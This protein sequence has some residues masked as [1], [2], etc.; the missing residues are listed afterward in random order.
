MSI[1]KKVLERSWPTKYVVAAIF[2]LGASLRIWKFIEGGPVSFDEAWS[3]WLG[4][5]ALS[6]LFRIMATDKHPPLFYLLMHFWN[7][8]YHSE[9]WIRIP[10]L[11]FSLSSMWFFYLLLKKFTDSKAVIIVGFLLFAFSHDQVEYGAYARM[12]SL[13]TMLAIIAVYS[14]FNILD[15]PRKKWF[16]INSL[17]N[18]LFVLTHYIGLFSIFAQFVYLLILRSRNK[19]P[20][21][22]LTRWTLHH[23][24]FAIIGLFCLPFFFLQ[25]H[26]GGVAPKWISVMYGAPSLSRLFGQIFCTNLFRL[27]PSHLR[28]IIEVLIVAILLLGLVDK[29]KIAIAGI[30]SKTAFLML[31][32]LLPIITFWSISQFEPI[33]IARYFIAFNFAWYLI[34][35]RFT[36]SGCFKKTS[37]ALTSILSLFLILDIFVKLNNP[38]IESNWKEKAKIME[39]NWRQGD[40]ALVVPPSDII[41][42]KFY[43]KNT[44][45]IKIDRNLYKKMFR[46]RPNP[47]T[48][49]DLEYAFTEGKFSYKRIWYHEETH[50]GLSADFYLNR[51]RT[52]YNFLKSHFKE[53]V[54]LEYKDERG[55]LVLFTT[56]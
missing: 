39:H 19:M 24:P 18:V 51:E 28:L 34:I 35:L 5:K 55:I 40:V 1:V 37:W 22:T 56:N 54:G 44:S 41:R 4:S 2:L 50:T 7:S 42:L 48:E 43:E 36:Q 16:I 21:S 38:Y 11:L 45:T 6:D 17:T 29:K 53:E 15:N 12:Y 30:D 52:I 20:R 27:F 8:S 32:Y 25:L 31:F 49:K 47:V 3:Y 23:A 9:S 10:S 14:F 26:A 13:A 33:F 46:S